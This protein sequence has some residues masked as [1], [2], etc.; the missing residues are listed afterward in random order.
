MLNRL[1]GIF[2]DEYLNL[3]K[4]PIKNSYYV[5]FND[6]SKDIIAKNFNV[7]PSKVRIVHHPSDM[8]EV[9]GVTDENLKR[10]ID[11]REIYNADAICVYPIRLDRGKQVQFVIKTMAKLK[12]FHKE[13]RC[14]IVDFHSSGGDK[15]TYRDELKQLAMDWGLTPK[16]IAFTS[17]FCNDWR[18]GVPHNVVLSLFRLSNIFI[19]PSVSESYSL[20]TQEAAL[21]KNVIVLNQDFPPYRDIFGK[22]AIFRKYSSNW[23]VLAGYDEAVR[24]GSRTQ[25]EY[26]PAET[27]PE[28]RISF[29]KAYH[30]QTAGLLVDKLN[31][32]LSLAMSI[33]TRKL[34][35]FDYIFTNELEPLLFL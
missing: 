6:I 16:E 34:R 21:N 8:D 10:F 1:M 24:D 17:E 19:M 29:E 30:K 25:T 3:F 27:S 15:V 13:V 18:V 11:K 31:N 7:K 14:I 9:F 23:D 5:Y 33:R 26:G 28:E 2:T 32:D 22:D 35:N 4:E 20:I 12:E